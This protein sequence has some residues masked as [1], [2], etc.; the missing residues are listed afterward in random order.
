MSNIIADVEILWVQETFEGPKSGMCKYQDQELWFVRL[1]P[2]KIQSST[3]IVISNTDIKYDTDFKYILFKLDSETYD[4]VNSEH[5]RYCQETGKPLKHG[6]SYKRQENKIIQPM[7][8]S[9]IGEEGLEVSNRGMYNIKNFTYKYSPSNIIGEY[10]TTITKQRF[11][12]L[13]VPHKIE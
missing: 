12:N 4:L 7:D 10:V 8:K 13:Y 3:D 5:I 6:D 1:D 9:T 2:P 11:S